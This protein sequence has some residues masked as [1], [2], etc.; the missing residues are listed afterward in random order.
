MK[1]EEFIELG[2]NKNEAKVYLS[3][4]KYGK[5]DAKQIIKDTGFH[6]N[7]IYDNLDK[8]IEKGLVSYITESARRIYIV[9]PA[10]QLIEF[11][12]Q[13]EE[14]IKTQKETARELA[15]QIELAAKIQ[16]TQQ[17]A[18]MFR[19]ISGVKQ[20]FRE[21][22]KENK[23]YIGFGGP[24]ESVNI[25]GETYWHNFHVKQKEQGFKGKL[26]FNDTLREWGKQM[27]NAP[28]EL[29]YTTTE[30]A[31]KTETL[32]WGNTTAIFVWVEKPIVTLIKDKHVA[33]SYRKF[34]ELLWRQGKK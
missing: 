14:Q 2:F 16:P 4:L 26:L 10:E 8:L 22:F 24:S 20:V 31:S 17:E 25:M 3:L 13:K 15:K 5:A 7:I 28:I 23:E 6:K 11:I 34:F 1:F 33:D 18:M 12:E 29:R 9:E 19:G 30:F 27:K 21:L 32:I